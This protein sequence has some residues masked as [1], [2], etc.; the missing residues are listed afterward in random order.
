MKL[1]LLSLSLLLPAHVTSHAVLTV[2]KSRQYYAH[3]EGKAQWQQRDG[4]LGVPAPESNQNGFQAGG[5]IWGPCGMLRANR[6]DKDYTNNYV[7]AFGDPVPWKS[8]ATYTEGGIVEIEVAVSANHKGHFEFR[9]CTDYEN[10]TQECFDQNKLVFAADRGESVTVHDPVY[11]ERGYIVST[12]DGITSNARFRLI[13]CCVILRQN[14]NT[15]LVKHS[16][17]LPPGIKGDKVLLQWQW[18][19]AL[20]CSPRGY[21]VVD[22]P[23]GWGYGSWWG[24]LC[25]IKYPGVYDATG[26]LIPSDGNTPQH[27]WQCSEVTILAS[28]GSTDPPTD[29]PVVSPTLP[30]TLPPTLA[31]VVT[32]APTPAPTLAP[33]VTSSPVTSAPV[34]PT[35][36]ACVPA[37]GQNQPECLNLD[38]ETCQQRINNEGKCYWDGVA[39]VMPPSPVCEGSCGP[40]PGMNQAECNG[41]DYATCQH[42]INNEGKCAWTEACN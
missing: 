38:Y 29:P 3:T 32:P 11:P 1:S 6:Y 7:D 13:R 15:D 12:V 17:L 30:P 33:V 4:A 18:I 39:P 16:Y 36:G 35:S 21:D 34:A 25:D 37:S 31:P 27:Y 8:Q 19:T 2:P 41:R 20:G 9:V 42:F 24:N 40:A 22:W 5:Y 28:D 14:G 26:N 23:D 10:P